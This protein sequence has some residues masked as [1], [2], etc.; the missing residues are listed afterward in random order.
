MHWVQD[1]KNSSGEGALLGG[2]HSRFVPNPLLNTWSSG[3][4]QGTSKGGGSSESKDELA[5]H[6]IP[7]GMGK[8]SG[9][10]MVKDTLGPLSVQKEGGAIGCLASGLTALA[11]R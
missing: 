1:N 4:I 3:G 9:R 2:W 5:M 8:G 10:V 7:E 6:G 11:L